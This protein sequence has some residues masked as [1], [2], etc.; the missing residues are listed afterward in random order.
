MQ[1]N[2]VD[3]VSGSLFVLEG[4]DGIGKTTIASALAEEL[5]MQDKEVELLSF[6]GKETGTLGLHVYELHHEPEKFNINSLDPVALQTLHIA[7]HIDLIGRKILPLLT[8]GKIVI[9]DRYW[10]STVVYGRNFGIPEAFLES[11]VALEE[12][13]WNGIRPKTVFLIDGKEPFRKELS[14]T[15]WKRL[16]NCYRQYV[17]ESNAYNVEVIN[18]SGDI[19][20]VVSKIAGLIKKAL[21]DTPSLFDIAGDDRQGLAFCTPKVEQKSFVPYKRWRP[22]VVTPVFDTYWRFA[23]ERQAIFFK[24]FRGERPPFTDDLILQQY[25][26]TNAYR[27]SDRVS[28]YLIKNVIYKGDQSEQETFFRIILFKTFN[29]IETWELFLEKLGKVTFKGFKFSE[30]DEI[31]VQEMNEKKSIYSAAY[32]MP[33]GGKGFGY[34]QKHKN[35]LC[36]LELMMKEDVPRRIGSAKSMQEVFQILRSYPMIGDFLAFQYAIDINYSELTNFKESSFV[37]PGP[38]AKEGLRKCF[39]DFGG[40]SEVDLI[41]LMTD[42]QE[43]E[44]KRLDIQF[45]SLWGRPLQLIDCQNLF[46][47]IAKYA[48]VAHPEITSSLGRTKIKQKFFENSKPI[49]L[50]YPPKWGINNAINEEKEKL[51]TRGK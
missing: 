30:Y 19:C 41:K 47:E 36:L 27:A 50:F 43:E 24:R 23:A 8:D 48:R 31:L 1:M 25:K 40:L 7:A 11:M 6:P 17:I 9:L 49:D 42:R 5:R 13:A 20:K 22:T 51:V 44:F 14:L 37:V 46:C 29:K 38:G 21:N 16:R 18:N 2:E 32:I 12:V 33:S 4:P 28:Q 3:R 26:F 45:Q 10:W 34:S 35:H 39:S 15:K